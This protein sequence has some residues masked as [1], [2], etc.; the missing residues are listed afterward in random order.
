M[1]NTLRTAAIALSLFVLASPS[2]ATENV[3]PQRTPSSETIAEV[4]TE[5]AESA[6]LD[7]SQCEPVEI[8]PGSDFVPSSED[9]EPGTWII[10][11]EPYAY[12]E[13]EDE[14][15]Y[16]L[17]DCVPGP[18]SQAQSDMIAEVCSQ[19][20]FPGMSRYTETMCHFDT[21]EPQ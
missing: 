15:L 21:K 3:T 19:G 20:A 2:L 18:L 10:G 8:I 1:R 16:P 7:R 17:P 12:S 13:Y 11:G 9:G 5:I 14:E 6:T 4:P